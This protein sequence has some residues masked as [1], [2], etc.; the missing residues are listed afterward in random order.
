MG[1][2]SK[3]E[4]ILMNFCSIFHGR[5]RFFAGISWSR[6]TLSCI[7]E[8]MPHSLLMTLD[9]AVIIHTTVHSKADPC[10]ASPT[11]QPGSSVIND[12]DKPLRLGIPIKSEGFQFY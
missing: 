10:N 6:K 3:S 7:S 9:R 8:V 11:R 12:L 2:I 1:A 4:P 5:M